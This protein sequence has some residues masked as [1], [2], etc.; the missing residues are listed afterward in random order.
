MS[1]YTIEP[2]AV[3]AAAETAPSKVCVVCVRHV[4][5]PE[6]PDVTSAKAAN[7][8]STKTSDVGSAK[9]AYVA[10]AKA[11][12]VA[13]AKAAAHVAAA[14][15]PCPPPPP[16]WACAP[17]AT[18]LQASTALAKIIITRPLMTFSVRMGRTVRQSSSQTPAYPR[19]ANVNV[20]ID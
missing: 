4:T 7:A 11:T 16:P 9:A 8:T 20:V 10:A 2:V 6:A 19:K 1:G 3:I 15:P 14:P 13:A 5:C 12:H 17:V 18:R